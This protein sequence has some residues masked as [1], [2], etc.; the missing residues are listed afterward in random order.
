MLSA[1]ASG[2]STWN[3]HVVLHQGKRIARGQMARMLLESR[4]PWHYSLNAHRGYLVVFRE[5]PKAS[6]RHMRPANERLQAAAFPG[7]EEEACGQ[8]TI[9]RI[10]L[11]VRLCTTALPYAFAQ[12]GPTT[13]SDLHVTSMVWVVI[14]ATIG[15]SASKMASHPASFAILRSR[16]SCVM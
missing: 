3:E 8:S 10:I 13:R 6:H 7:G 12:S 16:I 15:S 14:R 9:Y 4:K 5:R 11:R 2:A 1:Q